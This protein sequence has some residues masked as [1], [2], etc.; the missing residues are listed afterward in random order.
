[1]SSKKTVAKPVNKPANKRVVLPR[2]T[3]VKNTAQKTGNNHEVTAET[4]AIETNVASDPKV[5]QA[6]ASTA[7]KVK[8]KKREMV[9]TAEM[10]AAIADAQKMVTEGEMNKA[11]AAREVYVLL[12]GH[13]RKQIVHVLINGVGL[14]KAG[15]GTYYQN[16][17]KRIA[18]KK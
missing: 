8:G 1:M 6:P 11:E 15:A 2:K 16:L 3:A 13:E 4:N 9:I 7:V 17:S 10:Q 5:E 14:T 12:K 18:A